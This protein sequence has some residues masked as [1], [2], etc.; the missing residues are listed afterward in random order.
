LR[1]KVFFLFGSKLQKVQV[2]KAL[3]LDEEERGEYE[4]K[5]MCFVIKFQ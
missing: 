1:R 3:E 2:L 5:E 4:Y